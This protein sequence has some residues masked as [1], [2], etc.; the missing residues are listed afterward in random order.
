M[1][2]LDEFKGNGVGLR[3]M[4]GEDGK[5]WPDEVKAAASMPAG[6]HKGQQNQ[7]KAGHGYRRGSTD[8]TSSN[9]ATSS[10]RIRRHAR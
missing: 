1:L 8:A 6:Q 2:L 10:S 5:W 9:D 4:D 3:N 7:A